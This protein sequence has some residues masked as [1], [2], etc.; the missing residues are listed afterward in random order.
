MDRHVVV[1]MV[2]GSHLYGTDT[3]ESDRD[4]KG[5]YLPTKKEVLLSRTPKNISDSS[6][7]SDGKN[8]H[9]DVD[10]EWYSLQYF[11]DLG[12]VGETAVLDMLH[13]PDDML[14]QTSPIWDE[15]VRHKDKFYTR[16]L[17]ALVGYAKRQAAKYGIKGSRVSDIERV[18]GVLNSVDSLDTRLCDI[19]DYLP[20]GEHIH[21]LPSEDERFQF[22][23]VAGRKYLERM[24]VKDVKE[25]V[26]TMYAAYGNRARDAALNK[27]VD[28]K[29]L[30]HA[31][32]AAM[33]VIEILEDQTIT[34]PLKEAE[35]VKEVKGGRLDYIKEVAPRL[36]SLIEKCERLAAESTLPDKVDHAFWDNLVMD[37][38]ER[39][40]FG[41]EYSCGNDVENAK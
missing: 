32:R 10:R 19:W 5:V 21:I 27:N 11:V 15:I 35:Y 34:F 25:S 2:F 3:P 26:A 20:E 29:A 40:V 6:K 33:E 24:K 22:F 31:I 28:W 30:S 18:L 38:V 1:E 36:E 7:R 41:S 39:H 17:K 4:Y 12:R 8:T 16:S 23:Q 9:Y 13:A 37:V 14:I